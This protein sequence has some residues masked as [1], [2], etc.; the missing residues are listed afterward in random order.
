[1]RTGLIDGRSGVGIRSSSRTPLPCADRRLP[2][3]APAARRACARLRFA[4]NP[5]G[6]ALACGFFLALTATFRLV[7]ASVMLETDTRR[8]PHPAR[9]RADATGGYPPATRVCA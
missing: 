7:Y 1:M 3:A 8:V 2:R 4:R 5:A 6:E 9:N